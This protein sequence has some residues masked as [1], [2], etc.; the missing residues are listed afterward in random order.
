M[1]TIGLSFGAAAAMWALAAEPA[2]AR[3]SFEDAPGLSSIGAIAL[4]AGG[5]NTVVSNGG[6]S[7]PRG[8]SDERRDAN[9][10]RDKEKLAA[11][12]PNQTDCQ[13][14]RRAPAPGGGG[15]DAIPDSALMRQ[16]TIL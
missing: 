13:R 12:L 6:P 16:R 1:R 15:A 9:G 2:S 7:N 4:Q 5:R 14:R 3:T 8:N 10:D 11:C